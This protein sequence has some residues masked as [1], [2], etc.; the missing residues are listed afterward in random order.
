M[1]FIELLLHVSPDNGNG[2]TEVWFVILATALLIATICPRQL[3]SFARR[4]E[5]GKRMPNLRTPRS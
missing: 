1:D 2:V 3:L 4:C 5:D